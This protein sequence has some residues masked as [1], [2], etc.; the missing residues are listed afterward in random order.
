MKVSDTSEDT[1]IDVVEQFDYSTQN[2]AYNENYIT[3]R[4]KIDIPY[5]FNFTRNRKESVFVEGK[6]FENKNS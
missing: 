3:W 5:A 4:R 2:E 6:G 1:V